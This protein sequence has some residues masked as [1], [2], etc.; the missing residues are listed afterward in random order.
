MIIS[1]TPLRI[2]FFG[3]GTDY[4]DWYKYHR[5][6]TIV[7]TFNKHSYT[8]FSE[9]DP[10]FDY[11]NRVRYY[12]REEVDDL[13]KIKH[14][15]VKNVLKYFKIKKNIDLTHTCNFMANS[16]TGS[17][18][19]F[20]VGLINCIYSFLNLKSNPEKIAKTSIHI[21]QNMNK[22]AVGSQ[23][24]IA[25]SFGGLNV[26]D[27]YKGQFKVKR[28]ILSTNNIKS[29][30]ESCMLFYTGIK[31]ISFN[32]TKDVILNMKKK[33][34]IYENI[35]ST[36]QEAEKIFFNKKIDIKQLGELMDYSWVQKKQTSQLVSNNLIESIYETAKN[37]G[38]LGGK[39]LGGG[40]GGFFLIIAE[41]KDKKKINVCYFKKSQDEF[42]NQIFYFLIF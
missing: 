38:A 20:S 15:T 21:E 9:L 36:A 1:K 27:F 22:D 37:S 17:S 5:G 23:D 7:S 42:L 40:G 31:R 33:F 28:N 24:Q 19:A 29:L 18:S 4:P 3:G 25:V 11:K 2:S 26:I 30:E 8:F 12:K 14:P 39:I 41:N 35:Y 6:K 13:K 32:I 10:I 16:G 34:E